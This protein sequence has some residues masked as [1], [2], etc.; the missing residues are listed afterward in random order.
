MSSGIQ[1]RTFQ[2]S[3]AV[4]FFRIVEEEW[5]DFSVDAARFC[6]MFVNIHN[7]HGVIFQKD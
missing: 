2:N 1:S 5:S 4:C 6:E 7:A 3:F